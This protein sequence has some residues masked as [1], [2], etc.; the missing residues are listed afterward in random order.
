MSNVILRYVLYGRKLTYLA[1]GT[2]C[3]LVLYIVVTMFVDFSKVSK[4]WGKD[5]MLSKDTRIRCADGHVGDVSD[6]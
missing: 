4:P 6:S 1:Y 2:V 3:S 5:N